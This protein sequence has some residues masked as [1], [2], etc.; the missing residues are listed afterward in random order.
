MDDDNAMLKKLVGKYGPP[1]GKVLVEK[2]REIENHCPSGHYP[3]LVRATVSTTVSAAI[4]PS[5]RSL[6]F[7]RSCGAR[8]GA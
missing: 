2:R 3:V 6:V 7:G 1:L 8:R 4:S 5:P